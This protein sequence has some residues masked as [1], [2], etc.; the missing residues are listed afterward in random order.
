[1]GERGGKG[2]RGRGKREGGMVREMWREGE[3]SGVRVIVSD[4][5]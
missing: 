2:V 4:N 3:W 5:C 1:M